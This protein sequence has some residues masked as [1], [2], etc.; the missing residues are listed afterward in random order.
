MAV[1]F[2]K[3]DRRWAVYYPDKTTG[4]TVWEYFGRGIAAKA[5]ATRRNTELGLVKKTKKQG[6]PT[7][8]ELAAAYTAHFPGNDN[9]KKHLKIRLEAHLVPEFGHR[10]AVRLSEHD[11]DRY[12]AKRRKSVKRS[13]IARELTD[14]KAILNWA[15]KRRPPLIPVNPVRDYVKPKADD[16]VIM[17]P[18]ADE[19]HRIMAAAS[20]HL[21]R[22]IKISYYTGLRPGGVELLTLTWDRVDWKAGT[23]LVISAEK[24]GIRQRSVP[25]HDLLLADM[26]GWLRA[27]S[28]R[29]KKVKG[30]YIIHYH[31]K[32]IKKIQTSWEGALARA[33]ITRRIRPYDMR[34]AMITLAL[35]AGGDIGALSLV[36][37]SRPE[38]LRR[39]YQH[40]TDNLR[41]ATVGLI[42]PLESI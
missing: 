20:P 8:L 35:E 31:G 18:T 24:G 22:A 21:L 14:L 12:V 11:L 34:H 1:T 42:P 4:K 6:G 26:E 36:V 25:V 13:T 29:K 38:T 7:F 33:K 15:V 17:P 23:I 2:R 30:G 16:Q 10:S 32:G 19:M 40:V 3:S 27:D 37:G 28:T 41:R 9:S 39:H 5:A